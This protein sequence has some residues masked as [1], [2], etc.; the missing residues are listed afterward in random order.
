MKRENWNS[1]IK[2]FYFQINFH[3]LQNIFTFIN[4]HYV[5]V[6]LFRVNLVCI[7]P[8]S[9]WIRRDTLSIFSSNVENTEPNNSK[10]GQFLRNDNFFFLSTFVCLLWRFSYIKRKEQFFSTF[11]WLKLFVWWSM[12]KV[13][14]SNLCWVI[15]QTLIMSSK[16]LLA[17]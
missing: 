7:F 17:L 13:C 3:F 12:F 16:I 1:T 4:I 10:Y 9:D 14:S 8:H 11:P 5:K 2:I 6:S 15:S